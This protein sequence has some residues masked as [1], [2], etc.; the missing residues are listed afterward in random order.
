MI[1]KGFDNSQINQSPDIS[2]PKTIEGFKEIFLAK[3]KNPTKALETYGWIF[4]QLPVDK[5]INDRL[6]KSIIEQTNSYSI[7][8]HNTCSIL[9]QLI[10]FLGKKTSI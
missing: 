1:R 7:R 10:K 3:A 2:Y 9:R 8:R 5:P 6:L 4:E